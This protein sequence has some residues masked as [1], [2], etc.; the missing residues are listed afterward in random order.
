MGVVAFMAVFW[1]I[2]LPFRTSGMRCLVVRDWGGH[3]REM[4]DG[5]FGQEGRILGSA[6]DAKDAMIFAFFLGEGDWIDC[7]GN[8]LP[9]CLSALLCS[10][11]TRRVISNLAVVLF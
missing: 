2:L 10:G 6:V 1:K 4:I 11:L 9:A 7:F 5:I 3:G 8:S